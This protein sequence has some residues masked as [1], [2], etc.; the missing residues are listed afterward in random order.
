MHTLIITE[1]PN[2]AERIAKSLGKAKKNNEKG[3]PYY[4]VGDIFVAPA[5]G[6]IFGLKQKEEGRWEY[7]VFDVEWVPSHRVSK[8][9]DFTR[10]Y[11]ES[12]EW[13]AKKSKRFINACDYD[14]E[15][16]VIGYN[17]ICYGCCEDPHKDNVYRMKY[18][19]LTSDSI[20]K[21]FNNLSPIDFG[22]ADAGITRHMLDWYWG[23]NLSRALIHAVKKGGSYK[24]LSIGRVQG[25]TLKILAARERSIMAF[26]P[27]K[28]WELRMICV[29]EGEFSCMHV[30][31]K[32]SDFEKAKSAK[33]RCGDRARVKDA[34]TKQYKQPAPYPF[35]LTTLQTETYKHLGIDPRRTLEVAQELYTNAYI[36]Y[37]RT[38]SQEIPKD[39]DCRKIIENLRFQEDYAGLCSILAGKKYLKP[40]KGKKTDPAHPAIH[41]T[42]EKPKNLDKQQK[43]VYDLIVRRFLAAF[44]ESAIR[45]TVTV[46]LDNGGELFLAKGNTTIEKGWHTY[47]G[48]YAKFEETTLPILI[49]GED[50]PVKEVSLDEKQTK[51]PKRYTPA[52]I[53]KEME[54][55]NLGTK[56][57]RSQ[58]VDILYKR[59]YIDGKSMTVTDLGLKV[60]DSLNKYCPDVISDKLTRKFEDDMEQI[61]QGKLT[62]EEVI[63]EGR[64][65]LTEILKAFKEKEVMIGKSLSEGVRRHR[66]VANTLGECPACKSNLM[67]RSSRFG[68]SFVGCSNY[69]KCTIT[70]PLPRGDIKK[71]RKCPECEYTQVSAKPKRG[72]RHLFCINPSC[73]SKKSHEPDMKAVGKC[74]L[75]E[76]EMIVRKSRYG[77]HFIGCSAYPK[78]KNIW[79]LPKDRFEDVGICEKCNYPII[80]VFPETGEEYETCVNPK[81]ELN[82]I[83]KNSSSVLESVGKCPKCESDMLV[84]KSRF[85][86]YFAGCSGYPKCK[87][88]WSLPKSEFEKS[89]T[90]QKCGASILK[91]NPDG[92]DPYETCANPECINYTKPARTSKAQ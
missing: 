79:P 76:S 69:P 39:I 17:V 85:G 29:K 72:K 3:V 10:K 47:Y 89:N 2:V 71:S 52:S 78:C 63:R 14:V 37:P 81:C 28:Y 66:D 12:I 88:I 6:H 31:E 36:S 59:G 87:N 65:T 27:E 44:G 80:K 68:S 11:L 57:T 61:A 8:E 40:A 42:G 82:K 91:V 38:S 19:T 21:A 30:E 86:A 16:E 67:I 75:C 48:R 25:P 23:I 92:K 9:S 33:E 5:V 13:L 50:L 4:E 7:P 64:E 84:R 55:K 32:F 70:W 53:I 22:L 73:P 74:P 1:K 62:S 20:Q 58:I 41:P 56:A 45:Q 60:I 15:G 43:S 34:K 83:E 24:T 35:D 26:K 90:C 18:S 49:V 46:T 77:T 51:P 54:S